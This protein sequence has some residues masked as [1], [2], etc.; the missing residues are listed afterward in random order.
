MGES[1]M[2][3]VG[4]RPDDVARRI[5]IRLPDLEMNDVAALC[6]QRS[7]LHQH[8]ESGLGAEAGHAFGEAKFEGLSHDGEISIIARRGNLSFSAFYR[9]IDSN[10]VTKTRRDYDFSDR[11]RFRQ[12]ARER[13]ELTVAPVLTV[14][15][16]YHRPLTL[17]S[18]ANHHAA[19][20]VISQRRG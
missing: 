8:F 11:Q 19:S 10:E 15:I 16:R 2:Q 12:T 13:L 3:R 1:L 18:P 14:E 6:L 4:R 7:C 17:L 20:F 5:E 9:T